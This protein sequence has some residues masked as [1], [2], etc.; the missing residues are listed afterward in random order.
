M[1]PTLVFLSL[2]STTFASN[3]IHALNP[4]PGLHKRADTWNY[5]AC[6]NDPANARILSKFMQQSDSMSI[7]SCQASCKSGGYSY[8]GLEYGKECWCSNSLASGATKT[9]DDKCSM[10]CANGSGKCGA[11]YYAS[12]YSLSTTNTPDSGSWNYV[13]CYNDPGNARVLQYNSESNSM[14]IA[15]CQSTCK[16]QGFTYAGLEYGK[17][18]Y[19]GS[20]LANGATKASESQCSMS[21]AN[22]PGQCGGSYLISVYSYSSSTPTQTATPTPTSTSAPKAPA[23]WSYVACYTD[24]GDA[25][26]LNGYWFSS[27]SMSSDVCATEC[28]NRGFNYAGTEYGQECFC[29]STIADGATKANEADCNMACTGKADEKCGSSYRLSLYSYGGTVTPPPSGIPSDWTD[30]GCFVDSGSRALR[31]T[32]FA[33]DDMTPAKCVAYCV[34]NGQT[35]A[36]TQDGR[37]CFCGSTLAKENGSGVQVSSGECST[38]CTGDSSKKCGGGWR[39]SVYRGPN[40]L[41]YFRTEQVVGADF[42]DWF[43]FQDIPDPTHGRVTYVNK[44]TARALN[45]TYA[46]SDSFIL[47]TD[48]QKVLAPADPGRNSVR[49]MSKKTF[50]K[51]IAIFDIRHMP[52]GCGTWPAVWTTTENTWPNGGEVDILEGVNDQGPNASTLHTTAGCTMPQSRDQLGVTKTTDCN[53]ETNW[54]SGCGVAMNTPQSYGPALNNIGGGWFAMQRTETYIKIWFFPRNSAPTEI[55]EGHTTVNADSWGMPQAYFPNV[56]CDIKKYFEPHNII[57]NLTLCGD[58]AGEYWTYLGSGCPSTCVDF[59]NNNPD[60]LR[61]AYFDFA[62]IRVYANG[63]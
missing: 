37:E 21:C 31:A 62:S 59:V 45:L 28:K 57:I 27:A 50:T 20:S 7:Q 6:Y 30:A 49:L 33:A 39:L 43:V 35:L 36:G 40:Y 16:A 44:D 38:P 48:Y 13:A 58:W 55:R 4:H 8:A 12:V 25:R 54:N 52:Q 19:C 14:S 18:C 51:H 60:A 26:V 17:E 1:R 32:S 24:L 63:V 15:T 9:T 2:I 23:D 53:W 41:Q 46:T 42:Y 34:A 11:S 22:G 3:T 5:V 29:G 10:T 47:R 61:N 56:Q